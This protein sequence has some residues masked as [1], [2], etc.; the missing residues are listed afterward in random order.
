M[1]LAILYLV[2]S[3][4]AIYLSSIERYFNVSLFEKFVLESND[5]TASFYI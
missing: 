1:S 4:L 5:I 3:F 2:L